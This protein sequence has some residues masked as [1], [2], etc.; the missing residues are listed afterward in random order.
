MSTPAQDEAAI[1]VRVLIVDDEPY[2]RLWL[3]SIL[4]AEPDV[5]IVG[6]AGDGRAALQ[7]IASSR[8]DLVFLDIQMGGLDGFGVLKDLPASARPDVVFT[9]AHEQYAV[10]AFEARALDYF[11]KPVR[12]ER[13]HDCLERVRE[14]LAPGRSR[15]IEASMRA[16]LQEFRREE[17]QT[18]W[19][20]ARSG[21]ETAIVPLDE[22]DWIES[23]RNYVLLHAGG[24]VFH[25]REPISSLAT[26][27]DRRA[28]LR[29]HRSTVVNVRRI[30]RI[31]RMDNGGAT[32]LLKDGTSLTMTETYARQL[33]ESRPA[34]G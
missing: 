29:I 28:F 12:R 4:S 8:P 5:E 21:D 33:A 20:L 19:L 30:D 15:A 7:A 3:R 10:R 22:I 18:E 17:A 13:L 14:R 26:R 11:L 34:R 16:V 32:V 23:S 6:E 1:V 24:R 25:Y 9:T 2:A 27:L 31:A